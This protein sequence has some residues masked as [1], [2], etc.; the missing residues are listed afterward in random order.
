MLPPPVPS[1]RPRPRGGVP[2]LRASLAASLEELRLHARDTR[3]PASPAQV[4]RL[5]RDIGRLSPRSPVPLLPPRPI[6]APATTPGL[7]Q[8]WSDLGATLMECGA[9]SCGASGEQVQNQCFYLSLAAASSPQEADHHEAHRDIRRRIEAAVR[10]ARPD[11]EEAD[12]LG[13]D[14][15]AFAD[16]LIWGI[17][18]C[19]Q[20]RGRAVAVYNPA[21]G[22]CEIFRPPGFGAA[23]RSVL[24]ICHLPGHYVWVRWGRPAGAPRLTELLARHQDGPQDRPAVPTLVTQ[25]AGG[26]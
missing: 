16:F 13:Q 24:A 7:R 1:R 11:W 23:R 4:E 19:P 14:S 8:V 22:S 17:P 10:E 3:T 2:L 18:A 15:G 12:L 20:L 21:Q 9:T 25:T 26:G 5:L 6:V